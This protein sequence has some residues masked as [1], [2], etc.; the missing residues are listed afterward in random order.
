MVDIGSLTGCVFLSGGEGPALRLASVSFLG[1][2]MFSRRRV[3]FFCQYVVQLEPWCSLVS[4]SGLG[5]ML[6][7]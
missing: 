5:R 1:D 2:S 7:L 6:F 3:A 4:L